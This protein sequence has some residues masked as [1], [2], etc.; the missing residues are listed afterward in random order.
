[1]AMRESPTELGFFAVAYFRSIPGAS[2]F[3]PEAGRAARSD[4]RPR[5]RAATN[6]LPLRRELGRMARQSVANSNLEIGN[7]GSLPFKTCC[8]A[9]Q[10]DSEQAREARRNDKTDPRIVPGHRTRNSR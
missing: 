6:R 3:Q 10:A 7:H 9:C 1:M 5:E 4:E 8:A 2:V